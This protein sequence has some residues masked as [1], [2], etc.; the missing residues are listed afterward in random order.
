MPFSGR[1]VVASPASSRE[2]MAQVANGGQGYLEEETGACS[3]HALL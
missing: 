2:A 3:S 1:Q